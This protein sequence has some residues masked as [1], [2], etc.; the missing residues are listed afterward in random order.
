MRTLILD[1]V[2]SIIL[3]TLACLVI[4]SFDHRVERAKSDLK[5]CQ[6]EVVRMD[7]YIVK[8]LQLGLEEIGED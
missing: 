5:A 4:L 7:N 2:V 3:L 1:I 8:L 6:E